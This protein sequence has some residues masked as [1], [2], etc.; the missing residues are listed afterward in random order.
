MPFT[1][2]NLAEA[3]RDELVNSNVMTAEQRTLMLQ[4]PTEVVVRET[5]GAAPENFAAYWGNLG[6]WLHNNGGDITAITGT[7]IPG[8]TGGSLA[9]LTR[10]AL[11]N[12]AF[13]DVNRFIA[14]D[15]FLP[16]KAISN[17]LRFVSTALEDDD[18]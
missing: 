3:M 11:Y 4:N 16:I 18:E 8:R 7:N 2:Q 17:N 9:G 1:D 6:T 13:A 10:R 14:G 15:D 12:D 5:L